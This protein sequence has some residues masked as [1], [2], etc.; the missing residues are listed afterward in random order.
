MAR[1]PRYIRP[2][3]LERWT[4]SNHDGDLVRD[5]EFVR[6]DPRT[7]A[8]GTSSSGYGGGNSQFGGGSSSGG[9]GG[10]W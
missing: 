8:D 2:S 5:E 7:E 10:S 9:A 4:R 3:Q 6:R 1:Y